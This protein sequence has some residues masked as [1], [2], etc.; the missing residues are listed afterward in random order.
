MSQIISAQNGNPANARANRDAFNSQLQLIDNEFDRLKDL[1]D[2]DLNKFLGEDGID[3]LQEFE[4][5]Y[6]P[7]GEREQQIREMQEA[8]INPDPSKIRLGTDEIDEFKK[9]IEREL[10]K[11]QNE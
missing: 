7:N 8:L 9:R 2:D 10:E 11:L 1:T 3:Q 6:A 4:V 5:Y